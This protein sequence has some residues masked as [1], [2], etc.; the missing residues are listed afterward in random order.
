MAA[1]EP[2]TA[3]SKSRTGRRRPERS[4]WR[5]RGSQQRSRVASAHTFRKDLQ[6]EAALRR[7]VCFCDAMQIR[8]LHVGED[9]HLAVSR[10]DVVV[11]D[12]GM[13]ELAR[14]SAN[15]LAVDDVIAEELVFR[16]L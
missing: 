1:A 13:R 7:E 15:R 4:R 5:A 2:P 10:R 9:F 11:N 8:H 3:S 6:D 12:D 16:A 14:L